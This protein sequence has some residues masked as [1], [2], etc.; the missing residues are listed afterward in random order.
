MTPA[1]VVL[2]RRGGFDHDVAIVG[3]SFAGLACAR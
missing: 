2:P 3:G 1:A